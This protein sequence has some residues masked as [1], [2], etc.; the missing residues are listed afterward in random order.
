MLAVIACGFGAGDEDDV[1]NRKRR[2]LLLGCSHRRRC[3]HLGGCHYELRGDTGRTTST[4]TRG[5]H[6]QYAE[7]N[8]NA[9][10]VYEYSVTKFDEKCKA[11]GDLGRH[12]LP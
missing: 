3:A 5:R 8:D 1:L 6:L 4:Q 7:F 9:C 10:R 11:V 12:L 2:R